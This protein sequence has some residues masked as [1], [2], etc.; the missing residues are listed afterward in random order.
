MGQNNGGF[1][2]PAEYV[3]MV[4]RAKALCFLIIYFPRHSELHINLIGAEK[5]IRGSLLRQCPRRGAS[6]RMGQNDFI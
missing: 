4:P 6:E 3:K 5:R 2:I 1:E